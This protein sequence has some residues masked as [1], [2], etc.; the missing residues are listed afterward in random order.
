MKPERKISNSV[1]LEL[2]GYRVVALKPE[3]DAHAVELERA[4]HEG[5]A[6]YPDTA[7]V[8]FYDVALN[9]GLAYIH[10]YRD[11]HVTYLVSYSRPQIPPIAQ[12]NWRNL[13]SSRLAVQP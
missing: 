8:D 11:R 7:R 6:A 12:I 2:R 4:I 3:F 10:I 9:E 13:G 1:W 5:I